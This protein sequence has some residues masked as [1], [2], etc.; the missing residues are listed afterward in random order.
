MIGRRK[1]KEEFIKEAIAVKG[2]ESYD[3]SEV[4]YINLR[5]PVKIKC[6]KHDYIFF[7][8]PADHLNGQ[9]CPLCGREKTKKLRKTLDDYKVDGYDYSLS[10]Y[11]GALTKI[12]VICNNKNHKGFI[13]EIKPNDLK[14]GHGCPQCK[15]EKLSYSTEEFIRKAKLVHDNEYKYDLVE[16]KGSEVKVKIF[17]KKC[18]KY[19]LQ[20]PHIHLAG[21]GCTCRT[22][23]RGEKQIK[24][25]LKSMK[26]KYIWHKPF[27]GLKYKKSLNY[28][29]YLPDYNLLIEY[30][31]AQHYDSI[32]YFGGDERLKNQQKRDSIKRE[33]AKKNNIKLLEIHY[34]DFKKLEEIIKENIA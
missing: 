21:H 31:G 34:K 9:D 33:F 24:K 32:E 28:D 1:T 10:V 17:C 14:N 8:R 19:F 5:I 3:Y 7:Q 11:K 2:E 4:E 6:L 15:R 20:T 23:S 27:K 22:V 26:I 25:I 13:F 18:K 12:K 30:N 16:Y 29:F